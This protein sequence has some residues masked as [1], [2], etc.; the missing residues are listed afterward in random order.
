MFLK[1]ILI[2]FLLLIGAGSFN[3]ESKIN[4]QQHAAQSVSSNYIVY[5]WIDG[6]RWIIIYADNGVIIDQYPDPNY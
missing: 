3:A 6:V 4:Q 5:E 2:S 1:S